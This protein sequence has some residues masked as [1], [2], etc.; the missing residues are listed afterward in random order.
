[1]AIN[2]SI[3]ILTTDFQKPESDSSKSFHA[4]RLLGHFLT[5]WTQESKMRVIPHA[6]MSSSLEQDMW[7]NSNIVVC[8]L[9]YCLHGLHTH[10]VSR[11]RPIVFTVSLAH[12]PAVDNKRADNLCTMQRNEPLLSPH[13]V[14]RTPLS[15]LS[16]LR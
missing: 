11:D 5:N 16:P 8:A 10:R 13:S 12:L 9:H 2:I 3:A 15:H 7:M 6:M 1:M 14:R 4:G